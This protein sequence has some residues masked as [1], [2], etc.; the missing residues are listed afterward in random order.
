MMDIIAD[1]RAEIMMAR[2]LEEERL[3]MKYGIAGYRTD[4]DTPNLRQ[5]DICQ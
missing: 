4:L 5:W 2:A 1:V 3:M